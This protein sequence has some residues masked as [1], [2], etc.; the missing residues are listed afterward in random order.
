M[1]SIAVKLKKFL[2]FKK[3]KDDKPVH[4]FGRVQQP[5]TG[6]VFVS[7]ATSEPD[8]RRSMRDADR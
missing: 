1:E 4:V 2:K 8:F 6:R 3:R 7:G 5:D